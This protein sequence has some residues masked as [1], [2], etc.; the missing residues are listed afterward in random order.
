MGVLLGL[1]YLGS[2]RNLSVPI[3]A[4]GVADTV[5]LLLIFFGKYP[6]VGR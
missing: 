5:D 3:V 4:H 2:G 1:L 6:G